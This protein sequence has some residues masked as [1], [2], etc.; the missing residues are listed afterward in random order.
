M[1][2]LPYSF[3]FIVDCV[4]QSQRPVT[5]TPPTQPL[6]R[7]TMISGCF[8]APTHP[9]ELQLMSL[10]ASLIPLATQL[11]TTGWV[12]SEWGHREWERWDQ[13]RCLSWTQ[14]C[15][16]VVFSPV[17]SLILQFDTFC[18]RNLLTRAQSR[19]TASSTSSWCPILA[20]PS[21]SRSWCVIFSSCSPLIFSRSKLLT[22]CWRLSSKPW[23]TRQSRQI[24]QLIRQTDYRS[25]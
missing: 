4:F 15:P 14:S 19:S 1:R 16:T 17:I 13:W 11:Q 9:A 18:S 8:V 22:Y 23:N 25:V 20:M 3:K 24:R 21:S 7:V 2:N 12:L 5:V 10:S 6:H